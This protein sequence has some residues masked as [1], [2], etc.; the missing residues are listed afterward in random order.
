MAKK[1]RARQS[2]FTATR[3]TVN[4]TTEAGTE[5]VKGEWLVVDE[6]G[7]ESVW[8]DEKFRAE[9]QPA[10]STA[11]APRTPDSRAIAPSRSAPQQHGLTPIHGHRQVPTGFEIDK[12]TGRGK[13]PNMAAIVGGSLSPNVMLPALMMQDTVTGAIMKRPALD[14]QADMRPQ[15][16][17][18][19]TDGD[20]N[21]I[22][23]DL[24]PE[25]WPPRSETF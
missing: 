12:A 18:I 13:I 21:V 9:F 6:S 5:V 10:S 4:F 15:I 1:K 19:K 2:K 22:G 14:V 24:K 25:E 20:G 16:T 17:A 23:M 8:S 3:A 11:L 7:E